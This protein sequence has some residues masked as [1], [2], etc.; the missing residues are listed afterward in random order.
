[1]MIMIMLIGDSDKTVVNSAIQMKFYADEFHS[2]IANE[3][4]VENCNIKKSKIVSFFIKRML[5]D[6]TLV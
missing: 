1:M 6:H 3:V 4:S 2:F 5:S